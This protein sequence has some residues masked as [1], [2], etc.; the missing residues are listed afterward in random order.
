M[1]KKGCWGKAEAGLCAHFITTLCIRRVAHNW[2]G[3]QWKATILTKYAE[4][5][6]PIPNPS[7]VC[8]F[9]SADAN[10]AVSA[11]VSIVWLQFSSASNWIFIKRRTSRQVGINKTKTQT[12]TTRTGQTKRSTFKQ[13]VAIWNKLKCILFVRGNGMRQALNAITKDFN[14]IWQF[15][16]CTFEEFIS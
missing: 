14:H 13:N 7:F 9:V 15:A 16:Y 10:V 4:T 2:N 6:I 8:L 1:G 3:K 12:Q 11:L 5:P